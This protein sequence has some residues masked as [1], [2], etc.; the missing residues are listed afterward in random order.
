[1]PRKKFE[2]LGQ[3][4]DEFGIMRLKFGQEMGWS[5]SATPMKMNRHRAWTVAEYEKALVI[6]QKFGLPVDRKDM[7]RFATKLRA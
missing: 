1:M 2:T 7:M 3:V 5:K 6:A 4:L